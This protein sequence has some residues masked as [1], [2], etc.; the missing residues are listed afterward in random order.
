MH[1]LAYCSII[2]LSA[3]LGWFVIWLAIKLLF[4][5]RKAIFLSGFRLQGIFPK[6]QENIATHIGKIAGENF[7]NLSAIEKQ[8]ISQD[9]FDKLRPELEIHIDDFLRNRLKET[10]P[11]LSMF[12]GD[13][14]INQLKNAFLS[15]LE[16]LFPVIMKS[17]ANKIGNEFEI[18]RI[19]YEKVKGFQS[20]Q[21][22]QIMLNAMGKE[23]SYLK[24]FF[25]A[26]G[27]LFGLIQAFIIMNLIT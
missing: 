21:M 6:N 13:K 15:E 2:L 24:F 3:F 27:F 14:T 10:F 23:L 26:L 12:I 4:H 25:A 18:E 9:N 1:W 8:L 20:I 7:F 5:P 22:E 11:M 19:I 17:Y 16:T